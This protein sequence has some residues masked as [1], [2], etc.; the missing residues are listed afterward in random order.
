MLR[1]FREISWGLGLESETARSK[2][3]GALS[4]PDCRVR[5][6]EGKKWWES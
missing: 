1:Q 3:A 4:S 6:K 2:Y 5:K